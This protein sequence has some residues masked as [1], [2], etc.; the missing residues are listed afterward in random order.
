M[1]DIQGFDAMIDQ[2]MVLNEDIKYVYKLT[3]RLSVYLQYIM[4]FWIIGV[5]LYFII[6]VYKI[7]YRTHDDPQEVN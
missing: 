2:S 6:K 7:P 1:H 3:Y 5:L 4:I